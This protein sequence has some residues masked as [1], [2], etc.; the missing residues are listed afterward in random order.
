MEVCDFDTT[1]FYRPRSWDNNMEHD[2]VRQSGAVSSN[3][4]KDGNMG[5]YDEE[6]VKPESKAFDLRSKRSKYFYFP[7]LLYSNEL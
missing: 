3:I 1:D 4:R 5:W 2:V 7:N 6:T